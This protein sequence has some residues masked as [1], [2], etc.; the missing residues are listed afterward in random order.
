[1]ET[2]LKEKSSKNAKKVNKQ[3]SSKEELVKREDIKDTPFTIVT[4]EEE[5][6]GAMG[7]F[8]LTEKGTK[9]EIKKELEEITWNRIVQVMMILNELNEKTK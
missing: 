7:G 5:S 2:Q 1:M 9:E 3:N 4:I 6:F 8:R